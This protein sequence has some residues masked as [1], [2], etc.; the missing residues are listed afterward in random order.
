MQGTAAQEALTQA[1]VAALSG[2]VVIDTCNPIM[3]APPVG[4]GRVRRE[5]PA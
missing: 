1:G 5:E 2:K 4:S 3:D